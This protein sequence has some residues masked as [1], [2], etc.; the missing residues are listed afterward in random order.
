MCEGFYNA[1]FSYRQLLVADSTAIHR[2]MQHGTI[3]VALTLT[4]TANA[5]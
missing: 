5:S 1:A 4:H 2:P 3:E